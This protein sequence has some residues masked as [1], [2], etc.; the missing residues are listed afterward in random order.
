MRNHSEIE[1]KRK[2]IDFENLFSIFVLKRLQ[3]MKENEEM[4]NLGL[5][6]HQIINLL[7]VIIVI[8]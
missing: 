7:K 5:R 2:E 3:L 8:I 4:L 6:Y 1:E